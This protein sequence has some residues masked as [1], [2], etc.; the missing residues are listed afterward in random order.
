MGAVI[1]KEYEFISRMYRYYSSL[2]GSRST[3]IPLNDWTELLTSADIPSNDSAHCKMSDCDTVFITANYMATK[4][5]D[6]DENSLGRFQ[7]IEAF[8]RISTAK[9]AC[10]PEEALKKLFANNLHPNL[11]L[12]AAYDPNLFR[13]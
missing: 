13:T 3:G 7:L 9:Y 12:E 11:P 4:E 10:S 2:G 6:I 5:K 1:R 8:C